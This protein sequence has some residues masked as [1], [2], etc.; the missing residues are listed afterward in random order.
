MERQRK[1]L[2]EIAIALFLVLSTLTLSAFGGISVK[3]IQQG[4]NSATGSPATITCSL[5]SAVASGDLIFI[6]VGLS[7]SGATVSSVTDSIGNT[8]TQQATV[9]AAST[10]VQTSFGFSTLSASGVADTI[11]AHL[12]SATN[13]VIECEDWSG[14][15][16]ATV[17]GTSVG[18]ATAT[19]GS[20][21]SLSVNPYTPLAGDLVISYGTSETCGGTGT[22]T[23]DAAFTSTS[24]NGITEQS[25]GNCKATGVKFKLSQ[26]SQNAI[27]SSGFT[28]AT[29]SW[30]FTG[31]NT[32]TVNTGAWLNLLL[33]FPCNHYTS[34]T[35]T[36]S[37]QNVGSPPNFLWLLAIP[38]VIILI[39]IA[40]RRR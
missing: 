23:Y 37:I 35:T 32:I 21:Y 22:I 2:A 15:T 16:S 36:T 26:A 29:Y 27:W 24:A 1:R 19:T 10:A 3:L 9:T 33:E 34:T 11:T 28:Q 12:T 8:I 30:T 7:G 20:S 4:H 5:G 14:P 25:E 31:G 17:V 39:A 13:A 38:F 6:G 40:T 18:D